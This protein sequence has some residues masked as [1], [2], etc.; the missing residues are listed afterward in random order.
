MNLDIYLRIIA[1][2]LLFALHT[3]WRV[4]EKGIRGVLDFKKLR[5]TSLLKKSLYNY[6]QFFLL[7][8][9]CGLSIFPMPRLNSLIPILGVTLVFIGVVICIV[10]RHTLGKSWTNAKDYK[11]RTNQ[12]LIT[13]GVYRYIRHPI[14]LGVNLVLTGGEIL[15][16]SYLIVL[17]PLVYLWSYNQAKKEEKLLQI[18]FGHEYKNYKSKT[19]MFIPYII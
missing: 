2:I 14:Y 18:G 16:S 9:L 8:Q 17:L 15:V 11:T 3:Y 6:S 7:L 10:S 19:Y 5:F 12:K 4:S 1:I 13:G